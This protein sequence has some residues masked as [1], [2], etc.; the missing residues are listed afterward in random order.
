MLLCLMLA[1]HK[2]PHPVPAVRGYAALAIWLL[3]LFVCVHAFARL[4][5]DTDRGYSSWRGSLAALVLLLAIA[6]PIG[7]VFLCVGMAAH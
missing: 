7:W 5:R 2:D 3:D 1:F 4:I 6:P